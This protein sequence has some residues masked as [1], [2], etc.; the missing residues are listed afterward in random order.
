MTEELLSI[1]SFSD[2]GYLYPFR[3]YSQSKFEVVRSRP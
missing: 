1:T 2:V 3:R